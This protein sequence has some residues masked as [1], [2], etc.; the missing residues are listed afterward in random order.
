VAERFE[1][2]AR[3]QDRSRR[4][5]YG[6][7]ACREALLRTRNDAGDG[8]DNEVRVHTTFCPDAT[9][10]LAIKQ[11]ALLPHCE[12]LPPRLRAPGLY[13]K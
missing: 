7:E 8:T 12:T 9:N 2:G 1:S 10:R 4:W 11:T 3:R 13:P 6:V 5:R